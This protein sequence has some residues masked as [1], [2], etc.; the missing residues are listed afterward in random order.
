MNTDEHGFIKTES[1]KIRV[2]PWL[3]LSFLDLLR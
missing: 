2:Y 3:N 1:V